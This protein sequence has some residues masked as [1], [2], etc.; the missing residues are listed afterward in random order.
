MDKKTIGIIN[1][2][3]EGRNDNNLPMIRFSTLKTPNNSAGVAMS[4]TGEKTW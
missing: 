1:T 2:E 4:S 3:N